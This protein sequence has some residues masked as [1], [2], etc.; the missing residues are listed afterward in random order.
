VWEAGL[1]DCKLLLILLLNREVRACLLAQGSSMVKRCGICP[2]DLVE[3]WEST[4]TLQNLPG[5]SRATLVT[6]VIL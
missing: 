5:L 2:R 4:V 3:L 1:G 6:H